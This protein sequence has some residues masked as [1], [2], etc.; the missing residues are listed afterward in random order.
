MKVLQSLSKSTRLPRKGFIWIYD[1]LCGFQIPLVKKKQKKHIKFI[2]MMILFNQSQKNENQGGSSSLF[3]GSNQQPEYLTFQLCWLKKEQKHP[4][5]S[6]IPNIMV[7]NSCGHGMKSFL[8]L[9]YI[10]IYIYI[11]TY[12]HMHT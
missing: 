8:Q 9:R 6:S 4:N 1:D 12:I 5:S 10:Y 2:Q 3:Y 7:I 11:H